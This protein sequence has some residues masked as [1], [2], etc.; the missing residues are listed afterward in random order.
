MSG[1]ILTVGRL[2]EE[3]SKIDPKLEIYQQ[4]A[5]E[6]VPVPVEHM[7][8]FVGLVRLMKHKSLLDGDYF[9][10]VNDPIW[11]KRR[12]EFGEAFVALAF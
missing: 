5:G 4:K 6:Y 3:L 12:E 11:K 2:V 10:S 1:D 9:A 7:N 8:Y